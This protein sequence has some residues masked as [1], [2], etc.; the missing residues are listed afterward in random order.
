M[1]LGVS[2]FCLLCP[3]RSGKSWESGEDGGE[4]FVENGT[5]KEYPVSDLEV[6]RK[7]NDKI[8][9]QRLRCNYG[10]LFGSTLYEKKVSE[11]SF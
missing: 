2:I 8:Q 7:A 1:F 6:C 3:D 10:T 11:R 9:Y 4:I 5:I